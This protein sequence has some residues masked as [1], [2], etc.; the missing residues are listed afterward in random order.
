M[1]DFNTPPTEDPSDL[2]QEVY[3]LLQDLHRT[4][5]EGED[6]R[7][8]EAVEEKSKDRILQIISKLERAASGRGI[9]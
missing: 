5:V 2:E 6:P 1:T 7:D 8:V 9:L 3:D 4:G